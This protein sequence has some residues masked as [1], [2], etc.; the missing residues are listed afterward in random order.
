MALAS[1]SL[2]RKALA[3][4]FEAMLRHLELNTYFTSRLFLN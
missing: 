3:Y 2:I 1:D 4:T